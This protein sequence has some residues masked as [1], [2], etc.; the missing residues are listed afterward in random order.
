MTW[1]E[2]AECWLAGFPTIDA[3]AAYYH[4]AVPSSPPGAAEGSSSSSFDSSSFA[5]TSLRSG[6]SGTGLSVD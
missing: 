3:S 5:S 1:C 4:G 6:H 2:A